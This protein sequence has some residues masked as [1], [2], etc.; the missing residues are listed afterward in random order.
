[1]AAQPA[2]AHSQTTTKQRCSYDPFAGRQCWTETVTVAHTHSCGAGMTGTYPNCYPIPP[3]N[4]NCG[5]GT[6][7]TFPDCYPIPSDNKKTG[8]SGGDDDGGGTDTDTDDTDTDDT[9]SD[10]DGGG[11]STN[12]GGDDDDDTNNG[13]DDDD[14]DTDDEGGEGGGTSTNNIKPCSSYQGPLRSYERHRHPIGDNKSESAC[15]RHDDS[16]CPEGQTE[17]GAHGA[18]NCRENDAPDSLAARLNQIGDLFSTGTSA[19]LSKAR[20]MWEAINEANGE[21]AVARAEIRAAGGEEIV[22]AIEDLWGKIPPRRAKQPS[23]LRRQ[24]WGAVFWSTQPVRPPSPQAA[25]Q[26]RVG[27]SGSELQ[28][29]RVT[30]IEHATLRS[31][32]PPRP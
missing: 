32:S 31:P 9:D 8:D 14:D 22:R 20:A 27:S 3:A 7:G 29:Q 4:Q 15:H 25:R 23:K 16:H 30:W 21:N 6:T 28:L 13:G 19:A 10:D 17:T 12:N 1:M 26:Q 2:A 5:A 18:Q 24:C 11:T